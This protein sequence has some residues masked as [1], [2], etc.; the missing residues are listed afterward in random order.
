MEGKNILLKH[1]INLLLIKLLMEN[2]NQNNVPQFNNVINNNQN[3][4]NLVNNNNTLS[5]FFRVYVEPLKG[6][7]NTLRNQIT[8][9]KTENE[10]LKRT[11]VICYDNDSQYI[12]VPCGHFCICTGCNNRLNN[13]NMNNCPMCQTSGTRVR[14]Y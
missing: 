13:M 4:E 6:Y 2:N 1:K 11:C 7:I 8:R 9:L 12:F 5:N 3:N 14:V 10:N